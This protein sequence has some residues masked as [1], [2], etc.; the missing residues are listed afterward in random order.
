MSAPGT[1]LRLCRKGQAPPGDP[2]PGIPGQHSS[3][4]FSSL[5][6]RFC[7]PLL[8]VHWLLS[9][10][11]ASSVSKSTG[12]PDRPPVPLGELSG[13]VCVCVASKLIAWTWHRR[14]PAPFQG[15]VT[16]AALLTWVPSSRGSWGHLPRVTTAF[17]TGMTQPAR[18]SLSLKRESEARAGVRVSIRPSIASGARKLPSPGKHAGRTDGMSKAQVS[19][20]ET[21]S[22]A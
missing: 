3:K 2:H 18:A 7:Q 5:G 14:D 19:G 10:P 6:T 17:I 22:E 11:S 12:P 20:S 9:L 4:D 8:S 21:Q 13:S 1:V 16:L 15:H